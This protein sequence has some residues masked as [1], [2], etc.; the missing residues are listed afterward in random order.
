MT[1]VISE[2]ITENIATSMLKAPVMRL[3]V[4]NAPLSFSLP[5]EQF[6]LAQV[7]S[8]ADAWADARA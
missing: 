7:S 2:I 6:V 1:R 5:L 3:A 8:N 4:P